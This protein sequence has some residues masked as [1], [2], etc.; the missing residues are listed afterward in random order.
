VIALDTNVLV[1]AH[2]A[3]APFHAPARE[4]VQGLMQGR[5]RFAVP[6]PCAHEFIAVVTHPRVYRD[7]TPLDQALS[8]L[9]ALHGLEHCDFLGEAVDHLEM[10]R[11]LAVPAQV[12]GGAIHD[13]RIAALCVQHGVRELWS[14]D[15]DFSRYPS[16]RLRNP[17]IA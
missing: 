17:L 3:D 10:L 7:P 11:A 12:H 2:R 6:W 9:D 8:V 4:A 16:L 5:Q 1:Y 13:A 14:A 15:R